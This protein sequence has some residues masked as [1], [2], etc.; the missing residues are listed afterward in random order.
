MTDEKREKKKILDMVS[1]EFGVVQA[2][3]VAAGDFSVEVKET[4]GRIMYRMRQKAERE[5]LWQKR[6]GS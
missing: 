5:T 6:R 2:G 1:R 4:D 3:R